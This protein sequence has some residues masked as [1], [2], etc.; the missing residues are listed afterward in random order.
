MAVSASAVAVRTHARTH[1][2]TS[3]RPSVPA[4]ARHRAARLPTGAGVA[5]PRPLVGRRRRAPRSTAL[6]LVVSPLPS[7]GYAVYVRADLPPRLT[8]DDSLWSARRRLGR[9]SRAY[10]RASIGRPRDRDHAPLRTV[11]ADGRFTRGVSDASVS[12]LF[13]VSFIRLRTLASFHAGEGGLKIP[14][15]VLPR[16]IFRYSLFFFG[17]AR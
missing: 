3:V 6:S 16:W 9:R 13:Y 12:S 11:A 2:R 7:L 17:R 15:L 1:A 10:V 5:V 14:S 8:C 4:Y